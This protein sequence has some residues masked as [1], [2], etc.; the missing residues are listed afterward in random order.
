VLDV[1]ND[2]MGIAEE[3]GALDN[4]KNALAKQRDAPE[5]SRAKH[6][7]DAR[8][9]WLRVVSAL[10]TALDIASADAAT[11]EKILMPLR[12]AEAKAECGSCPQVDRMRASRHGLHGP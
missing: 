12:A 11:I 4:E 9:R 7:V 10:E 6:A 1:V 2:W 5:G 3:I 8:N